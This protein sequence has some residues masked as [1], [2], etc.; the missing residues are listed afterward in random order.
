MNKDY[1]E[2]T[3]SKTIQNDILPIATRILF[4]I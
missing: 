1:Y 3:T 4:Q 2:Q